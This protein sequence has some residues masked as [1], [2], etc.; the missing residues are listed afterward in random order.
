MDS[1][2]EHRVHEMEAKLMVVLAGSEKAQSRENADGVELGPPAMANMA[3]FSRC[4][5]RAR[6]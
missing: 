4:R 1:E 3:A 2:Y 6:R 5:A